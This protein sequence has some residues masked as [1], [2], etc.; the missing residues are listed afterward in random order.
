MS[1]SFLRCRVS[2]LPLGD[3]GIITVAAVRGRGRS[4]SPSRAPVIP[5]SRTRSATIVTTRAAVLLSVVLHGV[6]VQAAGFRARAARVRVRVGVAR[7]PV[8]FVVLGLIEI[9]AAEHLVPVP[10]ELFAHDRRCQVLIGGARECGV[11]VI[12]R[13][14]VLMVAIDNGAALVLVLLILVV[15]VIEALRI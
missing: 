14:T 15:V 12:V 13:Q 4:V 3:A 7:F 9:V 6:G 5:A 8:P 11:T 10:V 2:A 1:Q